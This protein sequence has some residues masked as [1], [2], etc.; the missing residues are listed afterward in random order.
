VVAHGLAFKRLD[1]CCGLLVPTDQRPGMASSSATSFS[2]DGRPKGFTT[3]DPSIRRWRRSGYPSS[4]MKQE[5][6]GSVFSS[7]TEPA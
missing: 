1:L 4:R 5:I 2:L 3:H 7:R 6:A